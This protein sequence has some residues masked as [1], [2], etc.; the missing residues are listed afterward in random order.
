MR[1]SVVVP[2]R[3][4]NEDSPIEERQKVY[5]AAGEKAVAQA[6]AAGAPICYMKDGIIYLEQPDGT[7]TVV[8]GGTTAKVVSIKDRTILLKWE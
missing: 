4:V 8:K 2:V 5:S 7:K 3:A 6:K 1:Y